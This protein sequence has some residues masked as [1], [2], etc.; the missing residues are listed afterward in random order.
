MLRD[1]TT[2]AYLKIAEGCSNNCTYC[3]IP[4]IRGK[5]ESRQFED[6][7]KEAKQLVSQGISELIIIAQD[8]TKYGIDLYGKPRLAEL[9]ETIASIEGLTWVRFLYAYPESIDDKLI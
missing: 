9:L 7:V 3:A 2:T 8:T 1:G 6:I 5:Y 4:K